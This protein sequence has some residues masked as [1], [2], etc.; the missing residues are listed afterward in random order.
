MARRKL[1]AANTKPYGF[2]KFNPGAGVGGHCI[3]VDPTYL[4]Y[5]A[6]IIKNLINCLYN[7]NYFI[8]GIYKLHT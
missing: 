5:V 3:P 8:N 1:D 2:M 7:I 6:T 4:A